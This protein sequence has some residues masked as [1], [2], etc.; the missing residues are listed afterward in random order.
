MSIVLAVDVVVL[1]LVVVVA[2]A[3]NVVLVCD[4]IQLNIVDDDDGCGGE[5]DADEYSDGSRLVFLRTFI[6][7]FIFNICSLLSRI[8]RR[9]AKFAVT[10]PFE[11]IFLNLSL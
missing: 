9:F 3:G 7:L 10:T 1:L 6:R 2:S 4:A 8:S 5:D 11:S